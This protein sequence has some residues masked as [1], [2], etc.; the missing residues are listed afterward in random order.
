MKQGKRLIDCKNCYSKNV[1]LFL[2][3]DKT[4]SLYKCDNCSIVFTFPQPKATKQVNQKIYDSKEELE[5]RTANFAEEYKRA[6]QH[7]LNFKRYKKSGKYLDVGCSYGIGLKAAKDLGFEV[8]GVEPTEKAVEYAKKH[9][10]VKVIQK[11]LEKAKLKS[12]SFDIVSLYD[13]LEHIPNPNKFLREIRRIL[14]P[15]GLIVIQSPNIESYAFTF[16]TT[17]WNWLLVP[18]H[19]WHLSKNS[20]FWLLEKNEFHIKSFTTSDSIYDFSSN[21]KSKIFRYKTPNTFTEKVLQKLAYMLLY[22]TIAV[23]SKIWVSLE[24]GGSLQVYAE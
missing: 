13:V 10:K 6:K 17:D 20:T 1:A 21:L 7:I 23:G 2:S 16:L 19:L 9:F 24:K 4:Y 11:T 18:N 5:S 14:K 8:L 22:C 15:Q 3:V 12:N